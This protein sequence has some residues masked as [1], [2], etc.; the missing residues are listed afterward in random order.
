MCY[1]GEP[2]E[3]SWD[4]EWSMKMD[5]NDEL[6]APLTRFVWVLEET[7]EGRAHRQYSK[8][9]TDPSWAYVYDHPND[10]Y[11]VGLKILIGLPPQSSAFRYCGFWTDAS[12]HSFLLPMHSMNRDEHAGALV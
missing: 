4:I 7:V 6:I 5:R 2:H 10:L 11:L 3:E 1:I 9:K 8:S 12:Q